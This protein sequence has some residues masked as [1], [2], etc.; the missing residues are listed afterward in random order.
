MVARALATAILDSGLIGVR[1]AWRPGDD[2]S[3]EDD[4]DWGGSFGEH[5]SGR[6]SRENGFEVWL[7]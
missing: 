3:G 2:N 5:A 6:F 1:R 7:D 4:R